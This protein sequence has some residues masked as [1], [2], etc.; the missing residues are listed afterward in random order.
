MRYCR[1]R[2]RQDLPGHRVQWKGED[3]KGWRGWL[4]I[5]GP[6]W[7]PFSILDHDPTWLLFFRGVETC[8]NH[9]PTPTSLPFQL[10]RSCWHTF[11][12]ETKLSSSWWWTIEHH[13]SWAFIGSW[14][15]NRGWLG[16]LNWVGSMAS[17]EWYRM[18]LY[19]AGGWSAGETQWPEPRKWFPEDCSCW[20]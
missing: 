8:W 10:C 5:S 13:C 19:L 14:V 20:D 9:Q 15:E 6:V 4:P 16:W 17:H 18:V 12:V 2:N 7:K 1:C 3:L 11:E